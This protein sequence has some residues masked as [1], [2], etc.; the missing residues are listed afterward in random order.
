MSDEI[1][2]VTLVR[3]ES[4]GSRWVE[5]DPY[6]RQPQEDFLDCARGDGHNYCGTEEAI[7]RE[8]GESLENLLAR[9]EER[10]RQINDDN[11]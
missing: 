9:A 8:P 2:H 6:W 7:R 5:V 10:A 1:T 11:E 3:R 4:R